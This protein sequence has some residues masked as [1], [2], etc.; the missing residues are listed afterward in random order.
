M[1][2]TNHVSRKLLMDENCQSR[3]EFPPS[4]INADWLLFKNWKK[5]GLPDSDL[6]DLATKEGYT[7][8]T[9]DKGLITMAINKGIEIIY[10]NPLDNWFLV[11][12]EKLK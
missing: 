2:N 7:I 11:K 5:K 10:Y 3:Q 1:S 4:F 12:S 8:V 9:R 6:L